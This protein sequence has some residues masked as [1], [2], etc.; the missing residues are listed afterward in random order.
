MAGASGRSLGFVFAA[1]AALFGWGGFFGG[2]FTARA[3]NTGAADTTARLDGGLEDARA[4]VVASAKA[5]HPPRVEHVFWSKSGALVATNESS[6]CGPPGPGEPCKPSAWVRAIDVAAP[7]V[8]HRR[9]DAD[10]FGFRP[11]GEWLVLRP[12][13]TTELVEWNPRTDVTS[14][15]ALSD[16]ARDAFDLCLSPDDDHF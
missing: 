1:I 5:S 2:R 9:A 16:K 7:N 6:A 12:R 4:T 10:V 3:P 13:G 8:E 14:P 15:S 11:D